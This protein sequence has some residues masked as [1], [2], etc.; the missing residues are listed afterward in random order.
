MVV[1]LGILPNLLPGVGVSIEKR[2]HYLQEVVKS[3]PERS[4][5]EK[6]KQIVFSLDALLDFSRF[7]SFSTLVMTKH[8]ADILGCL[9]QVSYAPL[10]K[11]KPAEDG[12]S[13]EKNEVVAEMD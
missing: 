1:A 3:V 7:K 10:K 5:L 8:I 11:P 9:I 6:Y 4:I 2:S 12:N 13:K